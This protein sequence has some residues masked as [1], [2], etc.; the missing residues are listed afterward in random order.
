MK[1]ELQ[2]KNV[3]A[4]C[5]LFSMFMLQQWND[6]ISHEILASCCKAIHGQNLNAEK[7]ANKHNKQNQVKAAKVLKLFNIS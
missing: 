1:N 4:F 2:K 6:G 7:L 5:N 3:K